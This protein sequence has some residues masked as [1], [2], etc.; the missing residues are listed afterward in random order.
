MLVEGSIS[1]ELVLYV[2]GR[3]DTWL[4]PILSL[5]WHRQEPQR[6][7]LARLVSAVPYQIRF[8][9][10]SPSYR[11]RNHWRGPT[12]D[13]FSRSAAHASA[14]SRG[15]ATKRSEA[16]AGVSFEAP[17]EAIIAQLENLAS[18]EAMLLR[19]LPAQGFGSQPS[20]AAGFVPIVSFGAKRC[21]RRVV[22]AQFRRNL[23]LRD[24]DAS[25]ST[26][27]IGTRRLFVPLLRE[28]CR[29]RVRSARC[30]F[31]VSES[32]ERARC[33]R[34]HHRLPLVS[35]RVHV[36]GSVADPCSRQPRNY[37]LPRSHVDRGAPEYGHP[38]APDARFTIGSLCSG[39][40][41]R[42]LFIFHNGI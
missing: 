30:L 2:L 23:S 20:A 31:C 26:G 41:P 11:T 17:T 33:V 29:V 14:F 28:T 27:A 16:R 34:W 12:Q 35:L 15:F 10:C 42:T 4:K 6:E 38:P 22:R 39:L 19:I 18:P 32:T 21:V 36:T 9:A 7:N 3:A 24:G 37:R 25:D 40:L 13:A 8:P 5:I 1:R